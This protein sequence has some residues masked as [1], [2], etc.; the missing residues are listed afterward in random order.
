MRSIS[1]YKQ[2]II[3]VLNLPKEVGTNKGV[4]WMPWL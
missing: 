2:Q 1:A 4:W 3:A